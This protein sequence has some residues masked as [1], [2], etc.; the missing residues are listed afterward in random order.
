V[1]AMAKP[2]FAQRFSRD[3]ETLEQTFLRLERGAGNA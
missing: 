3:G 2:D 1:A